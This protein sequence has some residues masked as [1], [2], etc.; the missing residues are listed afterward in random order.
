MQK[1]AIALAIA[2]LV[3]GAAFAQSNVTIYGLI[4]LGYTYS[5]SDY[6]KFQGIDP[7]KHGGG[8]RLGFQ[9][10]EALGN[11]LKAIFKL[12]W[13]F[14]GDIGDGPGVNSRRYSYVGL[15]GNFGT[16][17]LGR[18]DN[19]SNAYMGASAVMG[20][21][22]YEPIGNFR[23]KI[24]GGVLHGVRWENSIAYASPKFSGLDFRVIYSFG[25][26][27]NGKQGDNKDGR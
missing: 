19:V 3:S 13:G 9:G 23:E 4:D 27:V 26:K 7:A 18:D 14:S 15:A 1:K 16:L 21:N 6:K 25:E 5:K 22:G 11:G 10:E 12:E 17:T 8:N 24:G 20:I 2:G